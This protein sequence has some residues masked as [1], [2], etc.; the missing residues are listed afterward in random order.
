MRA[1][2]IEQPHGSSIYSSGPEKVWLEGR[3]LLTAATASGL[4]FRWAVV[5][6]MFATKAPVQ[7]QIG[8]PQMPGFVGDRQAHV[9]SN[10]PGFAE[11]D[12]QV[13]VQIDGPH[14][15]G[16]FD[17]IDDLDTR[18]HVAKL[19]IDGQPEHPA[20]LMGTVGG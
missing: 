1:F 9:G 14:I 10:L 16:F 4:L 19:R 18:A 12:A 7:G 20:Q 3:S 6:P 17:A 15:L 8:P 5:V 13:Q 2:Q 11:L